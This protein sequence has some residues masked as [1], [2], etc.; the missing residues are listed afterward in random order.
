MKLLVVGPDIRDLR[1]VKNFTGVQAYYLADQLRKRGVE[2]HF[3]DPKPS[4]PLEYFADVDGA[5]CDHVLALGLRYFTH[6][7]VGIA[8]ILKTKV[9]GAVTQL[10]DGLVHSSAAGMENVDCTFTFRDDQQRTRDWHRYADKYHYIGWAADHQLLY[11]E[12]NKTEL[13]VLIDHPYYKTGQPDITEAVTQDV[14][15]F[16]H[17]GKWRDDFKTIKV[18]RLVNNGAEDVT[19]HNCTTKMFDRKHVPFPDIAREYRKAHVYMVTHKESVGLTCLELGYCG[20]LV[21]TSHGLIYPDRLETMRHVAYE[22]V[23]APWGDVLSAIN[24]PK[25]ALVARKQTWDLV[26]YRLLKW[27]ERQG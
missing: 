24:V 11:P 9:P 27:F 16:A 22:G 17:T 7:P 8:T 5:G 15:A 1:K 4:N 12:Q 10:H 26:A 25:S 13:R 6:Q 23:R 3:I 18:R 14:L 19:L 2:L 20:A 21:V